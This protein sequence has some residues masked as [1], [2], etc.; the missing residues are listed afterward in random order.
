MDIFSLIKGLGGAAGAGG[1]GG[2]LASLMPGLLAGKPIGGAPGMGA[3]PPPAPTG[4]MPSAIAA[5]A[6]PPP[7]APAPDPFLPDLVRNNP[8]TS[9]PSVFDAKI[10]GAGSDAPTIKRGVFDRI[11]DFMGSD[12]GRAAM[13]RAGA[14][15]LS[16]GDIGDGFLAGAQFVDGRRKQR[17]DDAR[18]KTETAQKDRQIGIGQQNADTALGAAV[19]T[20]QRGRLTLMQQLQQM[21]DKAAMDRER[22]KTDRRGQD[23]QVRGQDVSAGV[24]T[25][26][27]DMSAG[28]QQRGQDLSY[29]ASLHGTDVGAYTADKNRAWQYGTEGQSAREKVLENGTTV[30]S[31]A[32]VRVPNGAAGGGAGEVRR[33]PMTGQLFRRDPITG[34]PVP[35]LD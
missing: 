4:A 7:A 10:P 13:L 29:D 8:M 21:V 15:M 25:R 6:A 1:E 20:D 9:G 18:Y 30:K 23:I 27:Q 17:T 3:A 34:R 35:V 28:T 12:E 32:T 11:G 31:T 19:S 26:G 24:Q 22:V 33:D 5:L 16:G 2:L 14:T